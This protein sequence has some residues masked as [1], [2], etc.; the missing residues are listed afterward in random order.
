M[1]KLLELKDKYTKLF[2]AYETYITPVLK[3]IVMLVT[4]LFIR[5]NIGYMSKIS[6]IPV[7]LVLALLGALLPVNAMIWV[8]A[9]ILLADLY[10]LSIEVAATALVLLAVIYFIYFRFTPKDGIAAILTPVCFKLGIPYVMP[11][12]TGL[13]GGAFSAIS[14]GCGTV[15]YFFLDGIKQNATELNTTVDSDT[16]STKFNV[17]VGQLLGNKEMYLV[18]A[19][20]VATTIVVYI[21]RRLRTDYAWTLAI[22]SGIVIQVVGLLVGY[23]VLGVS[24]KIVFMIIGSIVSLLIGFVIQFIFMNLDYARTERVQFEDDE[25]YYYV[26]AVPKKMLASEEKTVKHFGN[27]AAMGKRINRTPSN[28]KDK[29]DYITNKVI[30]EELDIDEDLLK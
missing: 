13:L 16:I 29:D 20:M 30:A 21:V 4:L 2:A 15:L 28:D 19:I 8:F 1:T 11:V 22:V 5:G 9:L 18:L 25:Y 24:G 10:A 14:V 12:G 6:S 17:T 7:T 23:L 26:K 3:F 27:T